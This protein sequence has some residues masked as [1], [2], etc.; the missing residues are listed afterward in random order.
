MLM[1]P[2]GTWSGRPKL[3]S[4]HDVSGHIFLLTLC[5]FFL[6][7]QIDLSL[8]PRP[9]II[10]RSHAIALNA[11]LAL[12]G[13]WWWMSLMTAVY[14]H[15]PME[16]ITGFVL[17]AIAFA[18]TQIAIP[19]RSPARVGVRIPEDKLRVDAMHLD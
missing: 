18:I 9:A 15:N 10:S 17:G 2:P 5:T 13:I 7:D 19:G 11:A 12:L 3:Y 14:F 1:P 4:G 6:A 8:N 16:K